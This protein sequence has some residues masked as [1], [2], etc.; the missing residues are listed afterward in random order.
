MYHAGWAWAGGTPY[1]STKLIAAHFGGTRQPMAV[2]WPAKIQHDDTPRSQFHHVIDVVPTIY[3]AVG[4]T[5]PRVVNGVDQMSMDGVSMTY[6]FADATAKG[7]KEDAVLRH[8][9]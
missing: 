2:S 7:R 8:H 3:D 6:T 4:I 5:A 9:G 1:K